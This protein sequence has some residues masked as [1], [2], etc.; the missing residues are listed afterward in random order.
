ME[1]HLDY[2][3]APSFRNVLDMAR[4]RLAE[5]ALPERSPSSRIVPKMHIAYGCPHWTCGR[6][7]PAVGVGDE[8]GVHNCYSSQP[9]IQ[10]AGTTLVDVRC[11][12]CHDCPLVQSQC[13]FLGQV[14]AK[15]TLPTS[16]LR[17]G[18]DIPVLNYDRA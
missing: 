13:C 1:L 11:G 18:R 7:G 9:W 5:V 14:L 10:D 16:S 12:G 15:K 3:H 2:V 6:M 8:A 4:T 17:L